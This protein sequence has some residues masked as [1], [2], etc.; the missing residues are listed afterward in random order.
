MSIIIFLFL[1]VIAYT[2][3]QPEYNLDISFNI[4]DS[5]IIGLATIDVQAG[6]EL[7]MYIGHLKIKEVT[8]NGQGINFNIKDE[9]LRIL[10]L[11]S[12]S[13]DIRYEGVFKDNNTTE[14]TNYGV[15]GSII[16]ERGISLTGI[17][18]PQL[19]GLYKYRL[20][21][22]LPDGYEAISE[23]E[24][25]AKNIKD[26]NIEFIFDFPYPTDGINLIAANRYEIIK[27]SYGNIEIYAYFFRED[28]E[29]AKKYIEYTK[30]YLK[31]YEDILGKFPYKRFSIVENFLPTGYSMPTYTLLGQ[32]IV[33]LLF[34]VET[35]L[36][37]EVLHQWFG[38]LV[39]I[40]YE[41][42]NWAEGLTTY[43]A[44]H[45]YEEQKGKGW[46][47]RKQILIDYMSYV[48]EKNE[49]PIRDFRSRADFSSK[50]IG[51]GKT[52]M[53]FH[54]LKNI[55]GEEVFYKSMRDFISENKFK[56]A[57]WDDIKNI[58]E[59]RYRKDLS[60]FFKQWV[61]I[62]G[63]ADLYIDGFRIK[64]NG[65]KYEVSFY[66]GQKGRVYTIDVPLTIHYKDGL[67]K[68]IWVR[69]DKVKT[70]LTLS[71]DS[72]PEKIVM[73]EDY[74]IARKLSSSEL[75]PVISRVIGDD[76][77]IIVLPAVNK[78]I[79]RI[80]IDY[81]KGRGAIEKEI[82][83]IM[84]SDIKSSSIIILGND[85]PI[86]NRLYGSSD[87]IDAKFNLIV[88]NN[89]WNYQKV[90]VIFSAKSKEEVDAA[91]R[92]IFHYGKYTMLSFDNGRN[93]Y[94]K[95]DDSD[96]G[97]KVENK[98][99]ALAIDVSTI[100][101]LSEI[102]EAVSS[103]KIVYIGEYHDRFAHHNVQL[104]VI[105]G[106]HKKNKK[107]AIGME[108]FQRPFQKVL[109]DYIAG[110]INEKE[111]LKKS[112]YF[113]RW[114]F[115]Y[116]LYKPILDFAVQEKIP[117]VAL[118]IQREIVDKVSRS[119][120]DSLSE[121][122]KKEIPMEMDFSD[123][124][125]RD[126]IREVFLRHDNSGGKNFDF[127]YQSQILWDETMSMSIDEFIRK[128]PD[129][130]MVVLAGGGHIQYGSG[131]PK[132]TFR[133]NRYDYSIILNDVDIEKDIAHYIVFPKHL[134]GVISPKLMV[135]LKEVHGVVSI[136]DFSENSVS[137]KAGLKKGDIIISLDNVAIKSV[138]DVR[139][140]LF[141]KKKGDTVRVKVLRKRFLFGDK[142]M[143]F[144]VIL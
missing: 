118:N 91:F 82:R 81:F 25:I 67:K 65:N 123:G 54:M 34:I 58:F 4:P 132:R 75:P 36:G 32:D 130:Q 111:F 139:I 39:Y 20:K 23:G 22:V 112:E 64:Q 52:A 46:E 99:Q 137:E 18:Y 133:R 127:F 80:I 117:V 61:D 134:D 126:R 115:D 116:N 16:N 83:D 10:P 140:H 97:I 47:Y 87:R 109:D 62:S 110:M 129:Y 13:L 12:G 1:P 95:I 14:D 142:E 92:K 15:V 17:W 5:R 104:E 100:K 78:E 11:Q 43:L 141:Y 60:E 7:V 8:L 56:K 49:F 72:V 59:K 131:I 90:V 106:L 71:L 113:K 85:N 73:D 19:E 120:I 48:N 107:I 143:E 40:D 135:L 6:K 94:K 29:L 53:I 105:K 28:I 108:M 38:N 30:K 2:G 86:I 63:M 26:G 114:G 98:E 69:I 125:Y 68:K 101:T 136:D 50:A 77:G 119:G 45:R 55:V 121:A 93:I 70:G 41:K 74:E 138:D 96:R 21:A 44:D 57:S 24:G 79:Y 88:K 124:E 27:D 51:Y 84:D 102:I 89:P 144:D 128:N 66:I 76:K 42:G 122:E 35:S 31:L 33:R 103:K 3:Q 37:H 9:V